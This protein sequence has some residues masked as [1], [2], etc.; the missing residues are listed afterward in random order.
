MGEG[1]MR[2]QAAIAIATGMSTALML[3]G[4]G[5]TQA[6]PAAPGSTSSSATT[7]TAVVTPTPQPTTTTT[8]AGPAAFVA[9]AK[10]AA[11]GDR[12]PSQVDDADLLSIGNK[13]CGVI[14]TQPSFGEAV[15]VMTEALKDL[16]TNA[17]E[18]DAWFR[19]AVIN[20]CPQYK[21]MLP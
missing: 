18:M 10:T 17:S 6:P 21:S 1:V 19:S 11:L 5:Q 8:Q 2:A 14:A 16:K 9:W 3:A 13:A 12:D 4:C 20:L 15:Q 7:S